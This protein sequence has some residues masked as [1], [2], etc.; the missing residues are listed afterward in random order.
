MPTFD[1]RAKEWDT[2]DRIERAA[3]VATVIGATVPL[4]GTERAIEVGAGTGLLGLRFAGKLEDLLLTDPSTGMLDVAAE[5]VRRQGLG[6]VRTH[7]FDLTADTMPERFDLLLSLLVLHHV[8]DTAAAF[9]AMRALLA[10][11]GR[12]AVAD[13][14]TEDGS[15]HSAQAEGLHHL[16]FDRDDLRRLA[17]AAGFV[18]V[19]VRTATTIED[20]G[21]RYPL[22][23][24]TARAGAADSDA[25][26]AGSD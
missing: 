19:A 10:A 14:D 16:G 24:L 23:L 3:E 22:F 6:N 15:V 26:R 18:D 1:E 13:L 21:R 9:A 12:I 7:R 11:G 8:E 25:S 17:E 2:T 20:E 5:K 4:S